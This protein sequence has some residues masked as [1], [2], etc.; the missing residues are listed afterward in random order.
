MWH[1]EAFYINVEPKLMM[2][3]A[4]NDVCMPSLCF[5]EII[6]LL[7]L[8]ILSI[9]WEWAGDRNLLGDVKISPWKCRYRLGIRVEVVLISIPG[10]N[11][12]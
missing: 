4:E 9:W 8:E 7:S 5:H 10:G 11:Q 12:A 6:F 3:E 1:P 2:P